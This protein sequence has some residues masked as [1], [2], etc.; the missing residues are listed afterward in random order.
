MV[1]LDTEKMPI[2]VE[3]EELL[4]FS[5]GDLPDLCDAAEVAI[6]AGGGFGWLR[7]PSRDTMEAY[8]RGIMMIPQKHIF[9]GRLDGVIGGSVQLSVPA[10]NNE[11]QALVGTFNTNFV[12][13]WARGHG[14]ATGLLIAAE[15]KA[16]ELGLKVIMLDVRNTQE[17]A[18][19]LYDSLGYSCW[20]V[21][22]HH[23]YI[24]GKWIGGLYYTKDLSK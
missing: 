8:W 18:I 23:A 7:P 14:I 12:A 2:S 4:E 19:K 6:E 17:A 3:I 21:N 16:R 11:A 1:P 20:G 24:D 13:P 5:A 22:P 15:K 10:K 9:V